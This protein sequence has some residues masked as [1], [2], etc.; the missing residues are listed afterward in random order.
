MKL[1]TAEIM[2]VDREAG[3]N[4]AFPINAVRSKSRT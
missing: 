2:T 1:A 3:P 4:P